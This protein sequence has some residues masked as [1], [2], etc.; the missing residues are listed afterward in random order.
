MAM[1]EIDDLIEA[2][3]RCIDLSDLSSREKRDL[4][5]GLLAFL[6]RFEANR[7]TGRVTD[8]LERNHCLIRLPLDAYPGDAQARN[9]MARLAGQGRSVRLS[10]DC[11]L[12]G[13]APGARPVF[14]CRAGGPVWESLRSG[15]FLSPEQ[16]APV[17][18]LS[19]PRVVLSVVRIARDRG[20]EECAAEWFFFA[21]MFLFGVAFGKEG[22]NGAEEGM[23]LA[24]TLAGLL[25]REPV[26]EILNRNPGF[27]A[28]AEAT[29]EF[30]PK[31]ARML[32]DPYLD[33]TRKM[34]ASVHDILRRLSYGSCFST[35]PRSGMD[36]AEKGL[37]LEPDNARLL[38]YQAALGIREASLS[39]DPDIQA[40]KSWADQLA[41]ILPRLTENFY[42]MAALNHLAFTRELCGQFDLAW[43]ALRELKERFPESAGRD[44]G[45]RLEALRQAGDEKKI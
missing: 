36:L 40:L 11:R 10:H 41:G 44:A 15:P 31:A 35:D 29:A 24:A 45:Q 8:I 21:A 22:G 42:I 20:D 28:M 9:C 37:A 17:S 23:E 32:L 5:C 18:D 38:F 30:A 26:Y 34:P 33:W 4:I 13:S 1:H 2:S 7:T 6:E 19:G 14:L 12:E 16:A 39:G 43:S 27:F 25:C 3:V